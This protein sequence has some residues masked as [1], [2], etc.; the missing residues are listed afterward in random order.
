MTKAE[1]A[2]IKKFFG[3]EGS[4]LPEEKR[5]VFLASAKAQEAMQVKTAAK[6]DE[7]GGVELGLGGV[8]AEEG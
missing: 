3:F 4:D 1:S 8:E 5:E 7:L 2:L 6:L